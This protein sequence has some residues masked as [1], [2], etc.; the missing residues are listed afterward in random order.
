M[1]EF[2]KKLFA[3]PTPEQKVQTV[4]SADL[5]PEIPVSESS[6]PSLTFSTDPL[7]RATQTALL[8]SSSFESHEGFASVVGNFDG[9]GLTCGA[10]GF[11][12]KFGR[13][14]K[15]MLQAEEKYPGLLTKYMPTYGKYFLKLA[16]M[17]IQS[18]FPT[19]ARL[20]QGNTVISSYRVELQKFWG[21]PE[22]VEI[23]TNEAIQMGM[24]ARHYAKLWSQCSSNVVTPRLYQFVFF[25]DIVVQN[26]SLLGLTYGSVMD[27]IG[28]SIDAATETVLA[29]CGS[30]SNSDLKQNAILWRKIFSEAN[31]DQKKLFFLAFLRM[32]KANANF[33]ASVMNRKGTLALMQGYVNHQ[34]FDLTKTNPSLFGEALK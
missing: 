29:Y 11:T 15:L 25:F 33:S 34:L 20:S 9:E 12:W 1:F 16:K 28:H 21:S 32:E 19:I 24:Q 26:G 4:E 5:P 14:Q 22:M 8:I 2:F 30:N 27:F 17:P 13:I 6:V 7:H 31:L 3:R 18:S 10:L 23:Q